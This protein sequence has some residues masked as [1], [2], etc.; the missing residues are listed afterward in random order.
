MFWE[1]KPMANPAT[2][3]RAHMEDYDLIMLAKRGDQDAFS[4]LV[5]RY[6]QQ[7]FNMLHAL[8]GNWDEAD[9]LAQETFL[10]AHRALPGFEGRA[11]FYTWLYRIGVNC[12]KDWCKM[13]RVQREIAESSE[14]GQSLFDLQI[15]ADSS[16]AQVEKNEM[17]YMLEQALAKLPEEYRVAVV[18]REIDGLGYEEMADVL[19]CSVGTVKSRLFRGRTQLKKLWDTRYRNY[20]QGEEVPREI[21]VAQ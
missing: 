19:N 3:E 11:Q 9:D 10:K 12:W 18:L 14:D 13:P 20:W 1:R 5:K 4:V 7:L 16:D 8:V 2:G 15:S 6:H 21:S 17:Q